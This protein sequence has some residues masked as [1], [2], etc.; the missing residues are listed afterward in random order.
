MFPTVS[1]I[2]QYFTGVFINLPFKTFGLFVALAFLA[3]GLFINIDLTQKYKQNKI[4]KTKIKIYKNKHKK[5]YN[6]IFIVFS[7]YFLFFKGIHAFNNYNE[8]SYDTLSFIFSS[9]GSIY[10]GIIGLFLSL[11]YIVYFY[12]Y[13]INKKE[14]IIERDVMPNDITSNLLL[15]TSISGLIGAKFFHQLENWDD[16]VSD[17]FNQLFSGGGLTFYGGLIFGSISV[18]YYVKR[19][20]INSSTIADIMAGPLMLA[21]AIGR[22]GCHMSGDGDWGIQ[23]TNTKPHFLEFIPDW[24][25]AYNYPNN[26]IR[27]GV[28]IQDCT[29]P[30]GIYC[31]K[32]PYSVYPTA[33]YESIICLIL[34]LILW[35]L[36]K[37]IK[38]SGTLFSIYLIFNFFERFFIEKIRVNNKIYY[39]YTQ[40][41]IISFMLIIIGFISIFVLH[42]RNNKRKI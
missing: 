41:E 31:Y 36:R 10:G 18:I 9:E 14:E 8:F 30:L 37:K 38:I 15:V 6:Y 29:D 33:I 42:L 2:V 12:Y 16:F 5:I 11:I 40:A 20:N 23:N 26:V 32:L 22:I 19:F 7:Y 35:N 24:L 25:W 27:L 39:D 21:Y 1:H 13:S 3:A 28:K 4:L 17:P 34:F